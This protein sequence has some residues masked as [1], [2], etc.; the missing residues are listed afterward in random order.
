[1]KKVSLF[2]SL[3]L[4]LALLTG[5]VG[6]AFAE[7]TTSPLVVAYSN[8]SQKFSPFVAETAYDQD[9]VSLTNVE[10]ITMDRMGGIIYNAI[11]GETVQ[12][13]GVDYTY[14]GIA[15]LD[16]NYDKDADITTYT[17]KLREDI[18]F[19]D[20]TPMTADD[21]IFNY[22]V[23]LDTSYVGATT[24]NSYP[25]IGLQNYRTQT[26]DDVFDKYNGM[27]NDIY[28]AGPDHEWTDAD[29][30]TQEQQDWLWEDMKAV[31][32]EDVQAIVN[33]VVSNY[34][35]NY[36][37]STLGVTADEVAESEGLQVA[38]GM[39][40]WGFGDRAV[41]GEGEEAVWGEFTGGATGK[42]WT[43]EGDD[44]PTA[45]DYYE[46]VYAAY[47]G[48]PVSYWETENNGDVDGTDVYETVRG[49]FIGEWGPKDEG[50]GDEGIPN[51]TGIKKVDDYTVTVQ[52][53]GY[54][55]P[56]IYQ[57]FGIPVA[58]LHYYGDVD[59]YD[60][61]NNQFGF[62]RGDVSGVESKTQ[63]P[64]GAGPYKFVE[65][66]NKVVYLEANEN[67]YK[68][69]PVTQYLQLKE[70]DA[71]D[72]APGVQT[73][74]VDG[75]ELTGSKT[76]FELVAS[77][78]SNGEVTGDIVTTNLVDN[79]GYGY[80]GMNADTVKV[81]D[82]PFSEESKS[83][84]K[85]IGTLVAVYRDVAYDSYYGDAASVIN[86]P[87]SNTSWAAPQPTDEDYKVA[88]STGADGRD[89]YTSEMTADEKY[90]VA[91]EAAKE[92][93]IAAGYTFDADTGLFTEAP[94]GAALTYELIIPGDGKGDH[95]SFSVVTNAAN[96]LAELG[97]TL[98]IND[99]ADSNVLWDAI[100]AGTQ[101]L[102]CAAWQSTVDPDMYQVYHSSNVIGKGGT[103]SN[104]YHIAIP[105]L[106]ELI[107]D[108]RRSDDQ[109]YRKAV[110]K[111]ALD[112]IVDQAVEVPA[113]Q[114]K[115]ST[116]WSTERI[117]I[118][119]MTPDMTT[120]WGWINDLEMLEMTANTVAEQ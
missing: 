92:Y 21:V 62:P 90:E 16:V 11:E 108:A 114:R 55:A 95:P 111:Q 119:T 4:V 48:D 49:Q 2:M 12:Y 18:T 52:T 8:F 9:V 115:N 117:M 64:L 105:E 66:T 104:N 47:E 57:I 65:Y 37:E 20:G 75:G 84:R 50:L 42:T 120:Y 14:T 71:G 29:A 22:Y 59:Q 13:N 46:E 76:N 103:D 27:F 79:R 99:P 15:D 39:A 81:G 36:A 78:N 93:F 101:E 60:Y 68:G 88:F 43:L 73:G 72:V 56:A 35:A 5:L 31:W 41:E 32:T 17:A 7:D 98:K 61:E 58:P 77:Y 96:A 116:I 28:A 82:D 45:A 54:E 25:I 3:V 86:Y 100:N 110:Y 80:I 70:T 87:I 63:N 24:L 112:I 44:F 107:V 83:L 94:E 89:L 51:I 23:Y 19:S 74:T 40:L 26:T 97:I 113:Y 33:Y 91:L 109:A 1:M 30:W 106:D 38:L 6:P 102:W 69:A 10:L 67:Y 85:A 34:A 53:K 118:E